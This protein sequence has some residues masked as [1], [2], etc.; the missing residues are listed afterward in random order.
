[1]AGEKRDGTRFYAERKETKQ[2]ESKRCG[3]R[4]RLVSVEISRVNPD[5]WE[6]APFIATPRG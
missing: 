1:M 5:P 3:D 2:I 6:R 4:E